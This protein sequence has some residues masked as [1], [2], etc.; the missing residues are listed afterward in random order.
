M[1]ILALQVIKVMILLCCNKKI[2]FGHQILAVFI[3]LF[4]STA[5]AIAQWNLE[6]SLSA[7]L[8]SLCLSLLILT[9]PLVRQHLRYI[10]LHMT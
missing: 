1:A 10:C 9:S 5:L 4:V 2:S 8:L 7:Y 3:E 6:K